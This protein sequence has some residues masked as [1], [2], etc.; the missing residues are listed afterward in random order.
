MATLDG[1]PIKAVTCGVDTAMALSEGGK[2]WV[3][4]YSQ[5]GHLGVEDTSLDP[6]KYTRTPP[7]YYMTPQPV[8]FFD[9]MEVEDMALCYQ[10]GAVVAGE[11]PWL[12]PPH[13]ASAICW[14]LSG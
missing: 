7:T 2:L 10:G 1:I 12:L 4:G 8:P 11:A 9:K 6:P 5:M 13:E 3:W 14:W